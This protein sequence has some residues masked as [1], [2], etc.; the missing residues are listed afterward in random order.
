MASPLNKR[1]GTLFKTS[2]HDRSV[3]WSRTASL[4][5]EAPPPATDLMSLRLQMRFAMMTVIN[6]P[7][8]RQSGVVAPAAMWRLMQ[9]YTVKSTEPIPESNALAE[10]M[11]TA[12]LAVSKLF[13]PNAFDS[14]LMQGSWYKGQV[15]IQGPRLLSMDAK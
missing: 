8:S 6:G 2:L 10:E 5:L 12:L 13:S 7:P 11:R 15:V 9:G 14:K 3:H 4:S 1:Y